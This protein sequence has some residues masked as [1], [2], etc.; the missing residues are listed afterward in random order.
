M[1]LS[2]V[3]VCLNSQDTI[4]DTIESFLSQ[5]HP[6]K[7]MVVVDGVSTDDTLKV[8]ASYGSPDIRVISEPDT[9]LWDAMNKGFRLFSG[10]AMTFLNSDDTFHD[11]HVLARVAAALAEADIA[12]GDIQM[13]TNHANKE[14]V[15]EWR[16]GHYGPKSFQLGWQPPHPGFFARRAIVEQTGGFDLSYAA[17]DYDWMLRAMILPDARI[18]YVPH[19]LADFRMGGVSTRSWRSI[20]TASKDTLRSRRAHLGAPPVDAA[21]FLRLA[22]RVLQLRKPARYYS[23]A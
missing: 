11:E 13:V 7:E 23:A 15:R 18:A 14:V 8:V 9:G 19:F 12:Y 4:R 6:D 22:R 16:A 1:R 5:T 21:I 17:A 10:E 2:V 3:T 20:V